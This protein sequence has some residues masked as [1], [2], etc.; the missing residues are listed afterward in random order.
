VHQALAVN[1]ENQTLVQRLRKVAETAYGSGQAPQQDVLQGPARRRVSIT[2]AWT[3]AACI[4][5]GWAPAGCWH[6][7]CARTGWRR[8]A[9]GQRR[10]GQRSVLFPDPE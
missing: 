10:S 4:S 3:P 2:I 5:T 1:G 7:T 6:S 9:L 8:R